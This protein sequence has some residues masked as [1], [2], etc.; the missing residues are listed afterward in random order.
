M[1]M[2][3]SWN[4]RKYQ[5]LCIYTYIHTYI[6]EQS[7]FHINPFDCF[8]SSSAARYVKKKKKKKKKKKSEQLTFLLV[9]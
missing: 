7:Y 1:S 8:L 6:Q 2:I 4:Y 9:R 3:Y 5:R